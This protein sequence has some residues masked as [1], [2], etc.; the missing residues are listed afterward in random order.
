MAIIAPGSFSFESWK[1]GIDETWM[2][3]TEL[4]EATYASTLKDV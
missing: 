4:A 1:T 2:I 3:K